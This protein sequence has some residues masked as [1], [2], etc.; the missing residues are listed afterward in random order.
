MRFLVPL[1]FLGA[2]CEEFT[3]PLAPPDALEAE[4]ASDERIVP[5]LPELWYTCGDPV[6][7]GWDRQ[8]YRLCGN[9]QAGDPCPR[10]ARQRQCDP[11]DPCNRLL[12][13]AENDPTDVPGGCPISLRA[14]KHDIAYLDPTALEAV[15]HR[16][17]E[18]RLATWQYNDDPF[19]GASHFGFVIDDDPGSP[20]VAADG[21][22]VDL[23]AYTSMAVAALQLQQQE[24]QELRAELA[25]LR[26]EM[27]SSTGSPR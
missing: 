27:R 8:P 22:H 1:L 2:A 24:I 26:A 4:D 23:Y 14:A 10:S 15:R 3:D 19:P 16:L 9:H 5:N 21:G 17:L 7:S 12:V 25:A 6:C 18:T 13:C 20:A 11:M